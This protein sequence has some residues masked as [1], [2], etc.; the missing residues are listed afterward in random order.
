MA[1]LLLA[2][3]RLV[4]GKIK[5]RGDNLVFGNFVPDQLPHDSATIE[6]NHPITHAHQLI[7]VSGVKN[8]RRSLISQSSKQAVHFLFGPD[9]D[10]PG[11]VHEQ[12]A[13]GAQ[14]QPFGH[15]S[16]L[17]VP[18]GKAAGSVV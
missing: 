14:E 2:G 15:H 7:I 5:R 12:Q 1:W 3:S 6:N 4:D 17:L 16:F 8:D 13:S 9:V 11:W 10:A 18:A